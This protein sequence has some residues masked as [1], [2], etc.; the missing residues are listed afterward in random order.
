L[1]I[2]NTTNEITKMRGREK[3]KKKRFIMRLLQLS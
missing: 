3:K 1:E 2:D